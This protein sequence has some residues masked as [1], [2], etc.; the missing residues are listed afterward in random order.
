[1]IS[2]VDDSCCQVLAPDDGPFTEQTLIDLIRADTQLWSDLLYVSGGKLALKKCS[3]HFTWY[4]FDP[5]GQ[6]HLRLGT[7]GGEVSLT[8]PDGD[9]NLI[10]HLSA[11]QSYKTL[12]SRQNPAANPTQ[13]LSVITAKSDSYAILT[14]T[15]PITR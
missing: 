15:A 13:A 1:M 8:T 2:F 12:G 9:T 7:F 11:D 10:E 14:S 6:P 5:S 3:Y 4:D